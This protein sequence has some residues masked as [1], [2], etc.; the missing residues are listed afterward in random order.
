L[1]IGSLNSTLSERFFSRCCIGFSIRA[2]KSAAEV[3]RRKYAI[4]GVEQ[5]QL[6]H[7]YRAMAWL[8]WPLPDEQ[9]AGATPFSP[10]TTKDLIEE[11]LFSRH[12]DLFSTLDLVF[13][14]RDLDLLR[15][16]RWRDHRAI[17]Q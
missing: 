1:Q 12:R 13:F 11:R 6:H 2:A 15:G 16:R 8:G 10:R 7:L 9:Q 14:F 3:W 17:W 5:L 4:P